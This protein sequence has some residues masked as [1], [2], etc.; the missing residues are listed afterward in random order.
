MT[1]LDVRQA[2]AQPLTARQLLP[3][4][5]YD[6]EMGQPRNV[7]YVELSGAAG[8]NIQT[9]DTINT[10]IS[11]DVEVVVRLKCPS[12]I[13]GTNQTIVCKYNT[14]SQRAWRFYIG[15]GGQLAFTASPDGTATT[16]T[17]LTIPAGVL[18]PNAWV[19]LRA[20]FD[21]SNGAN[22]VFTVESA[23][24]VGT[25]AEPTSWT[26]QASISSLVV[27][28]LNNSTSPLEIGA[29]NVGA[30][31]RFAGQI[32]RCIVRDGFG[33]RV[34]AD[35]DAGQSY[36]PGYLNE[37]A[38]PTDGNGARYVPLRG[39]SGDYVWTADRPA[40]AVTG[41]FE[42]VVWFAPDAYATGV[43]QSII[44][45]FPAAPNRSWT[46]RLRGSSARP[47]AYLTTDGSTLSTLLASADVPYAAGVPWVLKMDRRASDGRVRFFHAPFSATEPSSWT[48]LGTDLTGPTGALFDSS[49]PLELG[50]SAAAVALAGR[51]YR[52]IVRSGI[53]G[54]VVADFDAS[55]ATVFGQAADGYGN[56]WIIADPKHFGNWTISNPK[57]YDT[58]GTGKAPAVFGAGS[59]AP[60]WYPWRGV[61]AMNNSPGSTNKVAAPF[62]VAHR[63]GATGSMEAILSEPYTLTGSSLVQFHLGGN[64]TSGA[65]GGGCAFRVSSAG[66]PFITW[67]DG[68]AFQQTTSPAALTVGTVKL[69]VDWS[70]GVAT[71]YAGFSIAG[72]YV[73]LGSATMP[74][75]PNGSGGSLEYTVGSN[76]GTNLQCPFGIAR[77]TAS[78]NGST[79]LDFEAEKCGQTGYTDALG[80]A[81]GIT[82]ATA[83]AKVLIQSPAARCT[84]AVIQHRTDDWID[85]PAAAVPPL[86]TFAPASA[87]SISVRRWHNPGSAGQAIFT[88]KATSNALALGLSLRNAL[89]A[90][91]PILVT[92][93]GDGTVNDGANGTG[94]LGAREVI[95]VSVKS[96]SPVVSIAVNNNAVVT[97]AART[98]TS[99]VTTGGAGRI[100]AYLGGTGAIDMDFEQLATFDRD[101]TA[102]HPTLVA[103]NAGGL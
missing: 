1:A 37:G 88:T 2:V 66:A 48:Q 23:P 18:V 4:A 30:S 75:N 99:S 16:T 100:G 97:D 95:S 10:D 65:G 3:R 14:S 91:D 24:D 81:W 63:F 46:V 31:E 5:L 70:G 25:N 8:D 45:Q 101:P 98:T 74:S 92:Q 57:I 55:K 52:A 64:A 60:Q 42:T 67:H 102:D 62:A 29:F 22:S 54:S 87:I 47:L 89:T 6:A 80:N 36:G 32:G 17:P 72:P 19:W 49:A 68:S 82:R 83:G 59:N 33:G 79:V 13:T 21:L 28:G 50:A 9:P 96:S 20:R 77:V 53:G 41:D 61:A 90:A 73:L 34:V 40:L 93:L 26:V 56:G 69:K 38:L 39:V 78:V 76:T 12:Y 51:F 58:S 86:D 35:F 27:S 71:F 85:V 11:G 44:G 15:A 7:G 43:E 84:R 103:L 94:S